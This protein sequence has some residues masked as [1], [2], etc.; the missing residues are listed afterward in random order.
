M[1]ATSSQAVFIGT[2]FILLTVIKR[3]KLDKVNETI[4][5]NTLGIR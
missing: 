4:V 1:I 3:K 2:H 5:C